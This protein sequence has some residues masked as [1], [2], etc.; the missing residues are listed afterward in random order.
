MVGFNF[1]FMF[2]QCKL[3]QVLE[4]TCITNCK[5][6]S[7]VKYNNQPTY[8]TF[9][10]RLSSKKNCLLRLFTTYFILAS[11]NLISYGVFYLNVAVCKLTNVGLHIPKCRHITYKSYN[12]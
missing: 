9:S 5:R 2:N 1:L 10:K 8:I 3:L 11:D 12:W 7:V 4:T 6:L